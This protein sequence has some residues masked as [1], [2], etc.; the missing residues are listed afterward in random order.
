MT[1][2]FIRITHSMYR[3]YMYI[4]YTSVQNIEHKHLCMPELS[5]TSHYYFMIPTAQSLLFKMSNNSH[6]KQK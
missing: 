3:L 2:I 6:S 4:I 5:F 1:G